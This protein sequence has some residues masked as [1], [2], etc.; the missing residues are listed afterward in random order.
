MR[1]LKLTNETKENILSDLLKRS[2]SQ[3]TQY[4]ETV[5]NIISEVKAKGD[6]AVFELTSK[7]DKWDINSS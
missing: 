3:Y 7:F 2:P 4:E 5:A 1:I 6:S